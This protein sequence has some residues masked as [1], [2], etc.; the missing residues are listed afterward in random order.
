MRY[1]PK[2]FFVEI[3]SCVKKHA[4]QKQKQPHENVFWVVIMPANAR[5]YFD[6]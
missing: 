5:F 2:E 1:Q 3:Q 6:P 4:V